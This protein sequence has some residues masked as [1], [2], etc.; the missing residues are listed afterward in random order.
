M[1]YAIVNGN[2]T[3]LPVD[4]T[5]YRFVVVPQESGQRLDH[6]L[7]RKLTGL[8]RSSITKLIQADKVTVNSLKKKP[9]HK[10][11]TGEIIL[12]ELP[13]P[14]PTCIEAEDIS[15]DVLFE[16]SH[17]LV[18]SKPPG[19]V[20][21]PAAGNQS[22]TLVNGLMYHYQDLPQLDGGRPG[23]VHRLDKD[24]S[25]VMVI[26]KSELALRQLSEDFKERRVHKTYKALLLRSPGDDYGTINAPIGRHPVHR[27]KMAVRPVKGR[28][29]VSHW[30]IL[31]RYGN[32]MS[33][34]EI[35]IETGRTH[36]IRVHMASNAT[37]IVG[38]E[39]YGGKSG[40]CE[41]KLPARQML[42][43]Y[44]IALEHP[45]DRKPVEFTA[46]LWNDMAEF[47][48]LLRGQDT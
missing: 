32:G 5:D 34:A 26:A 45:V 42:H 17:L 35:E 30:T 22:G 12:V 20:V 47:L 46:P 19:L 48:A 33:L 1:E 6:Y 25:G 24:T 4:D 18:I 41:I 21:H 15:F 28:H 8:S 3:V 9:G 7:A 36:Q 13:E 16:D 14:E 31:E 27:K 11:K 37:P 2:S 38:D 44:H 23:I 29:A 43:A 40:Q 39:L 10:V